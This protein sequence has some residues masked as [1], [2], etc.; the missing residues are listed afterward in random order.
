MLCRL[1]A[2]PCMGRVSKF[3]TSFYWKREISFKSFL[4]MVTISPSEIPSA[5]FAMI[6]VIMKVSF[7]LDIKLDID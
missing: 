6:Y 5:P 7:S 1:R 4:D 2:R 3:K